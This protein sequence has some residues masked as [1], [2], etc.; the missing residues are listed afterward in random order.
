MDYRE[1]WVCTLLTYIYLSVY[2]RDTYERITQWTMVVCINKL[3]I[4]IQNKLHD[5]DY[6][7]NGICIE[8]L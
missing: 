8:Y 6:I 4:Y 3:L 7:F 1:K 2:G 5:I